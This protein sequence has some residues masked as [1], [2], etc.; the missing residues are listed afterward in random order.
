MCTGCIWIN[1]GPVAASC[2]LG[3]EPSYSTKG[4]ELLD[5][6]NDY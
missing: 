6:L 1:K 5:W 3:D 4:A 2:V